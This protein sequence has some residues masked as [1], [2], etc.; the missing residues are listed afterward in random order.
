MTVMVSGRAEL[1]PAMR[2]QRVALVAAARARLAGQETAPSG[3]ATMKEAV[4]AAPVRAGGD[5]VSANGLRAAATAGHGPAR[6]TSR[7]GRG[8]PAEILERVEFIARTH[9]QLSVAEQAEQLGI[10]KALVSKH[11]Q[12]LAR[13]GRI[14]IRHRGH[15]HA[16]TEADDRLL[17]ER[18]GSMPHEDLAKKIGTNVA[19]LLLRSKRLGISRREARKVNADH[20]NAY[21]VARIL[22]V[23]QKAVTHQW[24]RWGMLKAERHQ[25]LRAH[26]TSRAGSGDTMQWTIRRQDVVEFLI[27]Y[28]W[29]YDRERITD[30]FF[31]R[32]ADEAWSRDPLYTTTE[33]AKILGFTG[34]FGG[35][36]G[37]SSFLANTA[38]KFVPRSRLVVRRRGRPGLSGRSLAGQLVFIPRSTLLAIKASGWVNVK[39]LVAD[40]HWWTVE[41]AAKELLEDPGCPGYITRSTLVERLRRFYTS[42]A[43]PSRT[44]PIPNRRPWL[45]AKPDDVRS[46]CSVLFARNSHVLRM[47]DARRRLLE[48]HD[49]GL[50]ADPRALALAL[51]DGQMLHQFRVWM[52]EER[53]AQRELALFKAKKIAFVTKHVARVLETLNP[54]TRYKAPR[55]IA[56]YHLLRHSEGLVAIPLREAKAHQLHV[57]GW[58]EFTRMERRR[59]APQTPFLLTCVA[60]GTRWPRGRGRPMRE[61]RCSSCRSEKRRAA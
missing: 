45:L 49:P 15:R 21:D 24:I 14:S 25:W 3:V 58:C 33:A 20:L 55:R 37:V 23:D 29:Q 42:G 38:P 9:G 6:T 34:A 27:D 16:W 8:R 35:Q 61:P 40:P 60:C 17:R 28:P 11:R 12:E 43:I 54:K 10:S 30:T 36:H 22:G 47:N 32:V 50:L 5:L 13:A 18:I 2:A 39:T 19:G 53:Q 1:S 41:R 52:D 56:T 59:R 44:V 46:M 4:V 7:R 57:C 31:R 51:A 48:R 26:G